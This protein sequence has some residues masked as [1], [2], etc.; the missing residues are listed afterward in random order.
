MQMLKRRSTVFFLSDF[1]DPKFETPF[2]ALSLKHDLIAVTMTDPREQSLPDIGLVCLEDPETHRR[3]VVDT[4]DPEVRKRYN[5]N[6]Q[7]LSY[8]RTRSFRGLAVD[9]L[10]LTTGQSYV[11]PLMRFFQSREQRRLRRHR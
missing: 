3:L 1:I 9:E 10:V 2:K 7:A 6:A 5:E 4:A 8:S 11:A